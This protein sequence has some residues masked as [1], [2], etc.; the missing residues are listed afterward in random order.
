MPT[1]DSRNSKILHDKGV[2]AD[3]VERGDRAHGVFQLAFV[4]KRIERNVD[5]ARRVL[6]TRRR[7]QV[8]QFVQREVLGERAGG[9]LGKTAVHGVGTCGKRRKR[10]LEVP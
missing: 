9:E 3:L 1:A 8:L 5:A 2:G 6:R 4:E 7:D 10:S